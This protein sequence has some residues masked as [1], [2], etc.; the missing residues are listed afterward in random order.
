MKRNHL[1]LNKFLTI[2][3]ALS[4]IHSISFSQ[5]C[6][7]AQECYQKGQGAGN[8]EVAV[9]YFT[10][11]ESLWTE[12][13]G[14]KRMQMIL[15]ARGNVFYMMENYPK[16]IQ[17]YN[18]IIQLKPES[19]IDLAGA[20][21]SR[22]GVMGMSGNHQ[23]A[24][25]SFTK[26]ME[27]APPNV[28]AVLNRGK[29]YRKAGMEAECIADYKLA[30]ELGS[31]NAISYLYYD[32]KTDHREAQKSALAADAGWQAIEQLKRQGASLINSGDLS[33]A[34][35]KY[36]EAEKLLRERGDKEN[37][38]SVVVEQAYIHR[39]TKNY[40]QAISDASRAAYS[41]I[42]SEDAYVELGYAIFESGDQVGGF[43]ACTKGLKRFTNSKSILSAISW[44]YSTSGFEFYQK[45]DFP[46]AYNLYYSA[47]RAKPTDAA[48]I[49]NAGNAAYE[50]K[51]NKEALDAYNLAIS[52]DAS[53]QNELKPFIDYLK[54]V[55]K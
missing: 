30:A 20:Y 24:I 22:G 41:S 50:A 1:Y 37:T 53:L 42:S 36:I 26:A 31:A 12:S 44:M 23:G 45:K 10:K 3:L 19:N 6:S 49:R 21:E 5:D 39:K 27:I 17:D 38:T 13:E 33:S 15:H 7:S 32:Y 43:E 28:G 16:A 52:I 2:G 40:S 46:T 51:M 18:K 29:A 8:T 14:Q 9:N 11:A 4:F 55:V 35:V 48:A 47:Y 54:T 25:A 34:L